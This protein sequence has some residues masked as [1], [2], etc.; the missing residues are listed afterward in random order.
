M[1][2]EADRKLSRETQTFETKS[3]HVQ[4]TR[5]QATQM[6]RPGVLLDDSGDYVLIPGPYMTAD[7]L[8]RY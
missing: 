6:R 5:E 2:S 7:E 8:L 1:C 3:L 4:T